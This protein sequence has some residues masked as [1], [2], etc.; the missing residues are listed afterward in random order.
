MAAT[1]D[2]QQE[3]AAVIVIAV[4]EL[5]GLLTVYNDIGA[6]KVQHAPLRGASCRSL[7]GGHRNSWVLTI[8]LPIGALL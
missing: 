6:I 4:K 3:V 5:L 8:C 2:I 7:K 1:E